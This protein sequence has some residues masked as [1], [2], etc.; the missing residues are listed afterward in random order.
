[1]GMMTA[2]RRTLRALAAL[3]PLLGASCLRGQLTRSWFEDPAEVSRPFNASW[4][5]GP[6]ARFPEGLSHPAYASLSPD[7]RRVAI[8]GYRKDGEK[9]KLEVIVNGQGASTYEPPG[10]VYERVPFAFSPDGKRFGHPASRGGE[11]FAVIDGRPSADRWEFVK[12]PCFSPDGRRT[13]WVGTKGGVP[14]VVIDGRVEGGYDTVSMPLFSRDGASVAYVARKAMKSYVV[15]NGKVS[16]A[17]DMATGPV[18]GGEGGRMTYAAKKADEW[19]LVEHGA[20]RKRI[21]ADQVG[22]IRF[23]PDGKRLAYSAGLEGRYFVD[24][25]GRR[26]PDYDGV[27]HL[28]FSADGGRF[29]YVR[30]RRRSFP[31][32]FESRMA[33]VIDGKMEEEFDQVSPVV[34]SPDGKRTAYLAS[35]CRGWEWTAVID[36]RKEETFA[37]VGLPVFSPDGSRV[38]YS[39]TERLFK[40][41]QCYV[42]DGRKTGEYGGVYLLRFSDDGKSFAFAASRTWAEWFIVINGHEERESYDEL[43]SCLFF[44]PDGTRVGFLAR[45]KAEVQWK[46]VPVRPP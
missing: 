7:G 44:S 26:G 41:P 40:G 9:W 17:F 43:C 2:H 46:V 35:E 4:E 11:S 6:S 12:G 21:D 10:P 37:S 34:F 42:I 30:S 45:R 32:V 5:G 36:G 28:R 38:G 15:L 39:A 8:I 13:A 1:M 27:G 29:A 3:A 24:L 14:S 33:A 18:F 20:P 16:E 19:F 23:S 22:E 31:F 25:D